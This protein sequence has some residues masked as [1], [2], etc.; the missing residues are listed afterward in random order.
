MHGGPFN[1]NE[2]GFGFENPQL[3]TPLID[4]LIDFSKRSGTT[5]YSR[6]NPISSEANAQFTSSPIDLY[7]NVGSRL[8]SGTLFADALPNYSGEYKT[9]DWTSLNS[10]V[11]NFKNHELY[12][13]IFDG[14]D[15]VL[16]FE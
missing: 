4:C 9:A 15:N 2:F 5:F 10:G 3:D 11:N 12:G 7:Q 8:T 1:V 13:Q 16:R 6:T 14:Y